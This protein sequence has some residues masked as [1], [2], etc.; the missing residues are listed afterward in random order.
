MSITVVQ[1]LIYAIWTHSIRKG[2]LGGPVTLAVKPVGDWP[3]CRDQRGDVWRYI[4]YQ[5][6]HADASHI[7]YNA[8][9]QLVLG[10]PIEL[11]HGSPRVALIYLLAVV[12]GALSVVF[13]TPQFVVV[14]A[15]GGVYALFGV[16]L[17]NVL[18]N[19]EEYRAGLCNRWTRIFFLGLFVSRTWCSTTRHGRR[20]AARRRRTRRTR[21]ASAPGSSSPSSSSTRWWTTPSST[22]SAA[23]RG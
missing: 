6:V 7:T 8:L 17:G 15:S 20:A 19:F 5:F 21:A 14:G 4:G 3:K 18:L 2:A 16:H 1:I 10:A 12:V 9:V 23:W 13:A 11:V 22:G